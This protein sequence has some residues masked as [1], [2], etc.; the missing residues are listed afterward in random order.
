MNFD[1]LCSLVAESYFVPMAKAYY[2]DNFGNISLVERDSHF[3]QIV[4]D[5]DLSDTSLEEAGLVA[6]EEGNYSSDDWE[7]FVSEFMVDSGIFAIVWDVATRIVYVS[8]AGENKLNADQRK[9][10][11]EFCIAKT[12][13][14]KFDYKYR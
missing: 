10:L 3:D 12:S 11:R 8:A 13:E 14:L 4:D 1:T 2:I 5:Y 9:A 7:E 6:D